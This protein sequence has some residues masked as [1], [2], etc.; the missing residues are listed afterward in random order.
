MT[1]KQIDATATLSTPPPSTLSPGEQE[2]TISLGP[3][4]ATAPAQTPIQVA[5]PATVQS[6]IPRDLHR[7][8]LE[9]GFEILEMAGKGGMGV[10]YRAR[11]VQLG[12]TVALKTV[13]DKYRAHPV[14][15][16]EFLKEAK[17]MAQFV[18]PN[19]VA[20]YSFHH[21]RGNCFFAMEFVEG[22]SLQSRVHAKGPLTQIE[23]L[24]YLVQICRA[25]EE[26]HRQNIIHLDIKP[27]NILLDAQN[28]PKLTDFG[29][30]HIVSQAHGL[31]LEAVVGTPAF[32]APEQA[33]AGTVGRLTD[34]YSLCATFYYAMTGIR[35][36][37]GPTATTT[38]EAVKNYKIT[39][40]HMVKNNLAPSIVELIERGMA[41]NPADR[42]ISV[43]ELRLAAE[44]AML[45]LEP[46]PTK[47]QKGKT[48]ALS[49][50][51]PAALILGMGLWSGH[52][53]YDPERIDYHEKTIYA[54]S[55]WGNSQFERARR[56]G[57]DISSINASGDWK[58]DFHK[59][60]SSG[61]F[62]KARWEMGQLDAL[63][64]D[65]LARRAE[66]TAEF[67]REF[68]PTFLVQARS[69]A[70]QPED[71]PH[72][73]AALRDLEQW[74]SDPAQMANPVQA[75]DAM[76]FFLAG[77]QAVRVRDHYRRRFPQGGPPSLQTQMKNIQDGLEKRDWRPI[78][79][80]LQTL[81]AL[82]KSGNFK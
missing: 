38:I 65:Q 77:Q 29:L 41:Q 46:K 58:G 7:D 51:L 23:G 78:R 64:D 79:Q 80:A 19:I 59:M 74:N 21:K 69:V 11:D 43:R 56:N 26:A 20:V 2:K 47:W 57:I 45:Q 60:L 44:R 13:S 27:A 9:S 15:I 34:I 67:V 66:D 71:A 49:V 39:P 75:L 54:W 1:D 8:A 70:I 52:W 37:T 53:L 72:L 36:V 25:L 50:G 5:A 10:V 3:A 63:V 82:E 35:P 42:Y 48:L 6:N 28:T 76:S 62:Q 32:M 61:D 17:I 73:G 33:Q 16:E 14:I 40:L 18:H 55:D 4:A 68:L 24:F 12:R 30:S 81:D 22:E 31:S